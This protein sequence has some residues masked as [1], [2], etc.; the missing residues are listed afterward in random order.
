[1]MDDSTS[2]GKNNGKFQ[3]LDAETKARHLSKMKADGLFAVVS[4]EALAKMG[5][6]SEL[7]ANLFDHCKALVDGGVSTFEI[8]CRASNWL[9]AAYYI[10]EAAESIHELI[11][12]VGTHAN[13]LT[14]H[15][16][17]EVGIPVHVAAQ[18]FK[19]LAGSYAVLP[20][21][22]ELAAE[23]EIFIEHN[24]RPISTSL[25]L[26]GS[27]K[28]YTR[29]SQFPLEIDPIAYCKARGGIIIPSFF[30]PSEHYDLLCRGAWDMQKAFPF[31]DKATKQ[32]EAQFAAIPDIYASRVSI[33]ATGGIKADNLADILKTHYVHVAGASSLI[34]KTPAETNENAKKYASIVN[35]IRQ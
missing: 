25:K 7:R 20:E 33:C 6:G 30:T 22:K 17:M 13:I 35:E 31:N 16:A 23:F 12:A 28:E 5:Q 19:P 8:T 4:K 1:M 32:W 24:L 3:V 18:G 14:V 26:N 34:G 27:N 9:E 11:P 15:A 2:N 29:M 21:Q 10:V